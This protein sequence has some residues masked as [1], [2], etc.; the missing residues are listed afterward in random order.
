MPMRA[1]APAR[2]F[3]LGRTC[4][5]FPDAAPYEL[6]VETQQLANI[7]EGKEPIV[8]FLHDPLLH[9]AKPLPPGS[10]ARC[11]VLAVTVNRVFQNRHEQRLFRLQ[12]FA[13]PEG[14]EVLVAQGVI[15]S[16]EN[17]IFFCHRT[18]PWLARRWGTM[19]VD[20]QP[21]CHWICQGLRMSLCMD[22]IFSFAT[23]HRCK[24]AVVNP[25]GIAENLRFTVAW[26][27]RFNKWQNRL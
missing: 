26:P 21:I 17:E 20:V 27:L 8:A 9:F 11:A 10:I 24:M 19:A 7:I 23:S 15:V 1:G 3:G 18:P 13:A 12:V 25:C 16:G 2:S 4:A 6:W 22:A 5:Q 14:G